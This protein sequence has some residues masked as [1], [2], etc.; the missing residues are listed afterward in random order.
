MI[1]TAMLAL[2]AFTMLPDCLPFATL[3]R[4][5]ARRGPREEVQVCVGRGDDRG[6]FTF[7][8]A[9][10]SAGGEQTRFTATSRACPAAL[11]ILQR[12]ETLALPTPDVPGY[13]DE[14]RRLTLDGIEYRLETLATFGDRGGKV[15]LTSNVGTPLAEW[16]EAIFGALEGCW[17][18]AG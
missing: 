9:A 14:A 11:P 6:H 18:P 16:A 8:R 2:S 7:A 17:R 1:T 3:S 5:P 4:S 10:S 13:G 15:Q 12:M